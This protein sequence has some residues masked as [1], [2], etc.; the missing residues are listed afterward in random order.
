MYSSHIRNPTYIRQFYDFGGMNWGKIMPTDL[1]GL[2][3]YRDK[4][5]IFFE[6]KHGNKTQLPDGQKLAL[7]RLIDNLKK[8][9][10]LFVATDESN[11]STVYARSMIVRE[12]YYQKKWYPMNG[13][14]ITLKYFVDFF[15][16]IAGR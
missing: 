13:S 10:I 3:E 8:P 6:L 2:I 15:I 11:Q 5:F 12:Y 4:C 1:D 16:G 7:V 9:A 14:N